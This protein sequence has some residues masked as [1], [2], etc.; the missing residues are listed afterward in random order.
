LLERLEE[1]LAR[2]KR[3]AQEAAHELRTPLTNLRLR[4]ERLCRDAG[5]SSEIGNQASAAL[6]NL[7]ALDQLIES[8]LILARSEGGDLPVAPVNICDLIREAA[9][10]PE[11]VADAAALT[12]KVDAPDEVL[13]LGNEELLVQAV[14]NVLENA[15]KYAGPSA[16]IHLGA[17]ESEGYGVISVEDDGPG[18]PIELRE[19]VFDRFYRGPLH[20]NQIPGTGLGLA[21]VSAIVRRHGG[22]VATG[23]STLGG[24]Q[25]LLSIPLLT[26]KFPD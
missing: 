19:I 6:T 3:F 17:F 21:V 4:M 11:A 16:E 13:V 1:M 20:R 7:D 10:S 8:L 22:R 24:E 14:T 23:P 26:P 9:A 5:E 25:L 15:R 18:I 2:E 12:V